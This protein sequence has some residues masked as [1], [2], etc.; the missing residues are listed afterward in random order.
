[1]ITIVKRKIYR[2]KRDFCSSRKKSDFYDNIIVDILLVE[3]GVVLA[4]CAYYVFKWYYLNTNVDCNGCWHIRLI[5]W[6]IV[7]VNYWLWSQSYDVYSYAI[8]CR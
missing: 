4:A 2:L 3:N 5:C 8:I 7:V 6:R 1:M